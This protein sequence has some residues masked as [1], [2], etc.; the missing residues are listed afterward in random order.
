MSTRAVRTN[1]QRRQ[2]FCRAALNGEA[3]EVG[4]TCAG[5]RH[6]GWPRRPFLDVV[7]LEVCHVSEAR[8]T[9]KILGPGNAGGALLKSFVF[10]VEETAMV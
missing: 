10:G 1:G 4:A 5:D 8:H 9:F 2:S 3:T 6:R 7:G